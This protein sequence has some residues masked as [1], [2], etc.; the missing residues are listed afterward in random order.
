[1]VFSHFKA[2]PPHQSQCFKLFSSCSCF[3]VF[4]YNV[5]LWSSLG[6]WLSGHSWVPFHSPPSV[7]SLISLSGPLNPHFCHFHASEILTWI[8][9]SLFD[10]CILF[11][12]LVFIFLTSKT[13]AENPLLSL[14]SPIEFSLNNFPFFKTSLRYTTIF[15]TSTEYFIVMLFLYLS[16]HPTY[17]SSFWGL[18]QNGACISWF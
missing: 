9:A 15:L 2:L 7:K 4:I 8:L 16:S 1:M 14:V 11:C 18:S 13:I 12:L 3:L 10:N 5:S 17:C 6:F